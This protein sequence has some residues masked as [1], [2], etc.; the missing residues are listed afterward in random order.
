MIYLNLKN[1]RK[2]VVRYNCYLL[3]YMYSVYQLS[4]QEYLPSV[5]YKITHITARIANFLLFADMLETRRPLLFNA[6]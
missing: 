1:H 3:T 5:R 4:L 2:F 6:V